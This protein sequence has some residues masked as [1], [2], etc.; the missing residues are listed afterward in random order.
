[1]TEDLR[2]LAQFFLKKFP[3]DVN[4]RHAKKPEHKPYF[5]T[6]FSAVLG[7]QCRNVGD[8]MDKI[9]LANSLLD[10]ASQIFLVGEIGLAAVYALGFDI[11]RVERCDSLDKQKADYQ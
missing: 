1:M 5:A 8:I 10:H 6:K 2:K 4:L 9:L 7:G 11:S 3:L